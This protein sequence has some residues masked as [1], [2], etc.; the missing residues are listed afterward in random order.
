[1]TDQESAQ[2]EVPV[3]APETPTVPEAAPPQTQAS[4]TPEAPRTMQDLFGVHHNEFVAKGTLTE[5][6][7][8]DIAQ[9][10]GM[11]MADVRLQYNA[12]RAERQDTVNGIYERAGGQETW[13]EASEWFRGAPE[14]VLSNERKQELAQ[15]FTTGN[16]Q[17]VNLAVDAIVSAYQRHGGGNTTGNLA[18]AAAHVADAT[19]AG[20]SADM[21]AGELLELSKTNP[22]AFMNAVESRL[23]K[24]GGIF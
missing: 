13:R 21:D 22:Q 23:S 15:A 14:S 1:M 20:A 6:A 9:S 10:K 11:A 18:A 2:P 7:L 3:T 4:P 19:G 8:A 16:P 12:F 24:S 17:V 5:Q